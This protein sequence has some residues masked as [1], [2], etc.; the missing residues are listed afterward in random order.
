[1]KL[2]LIS[3]VRSPESEYSAKGVRTANVTRDTL[4]PPV[5]H[6]L[7]RSLNERIIDVSLRNDRARWRTA[8]RS[9]ERGT[10]GWW[11]RERERMVCR[12]SRNEIDFQIFFQTGSNPKHP[13]RRSADN[14]NMFWNVS[15]SLWGSLDWSEAGVS[16]L[17]RE[18]AVSSLSKRA[19][20]PLKWTAHMTQFLRAY[21][22]NRLKM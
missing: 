2:C 21:A 22:I 4:S 3:W 10:R 1:M 5:G 6:F 16:M 17:T 19:A 18:M 7:D 9:S 14:N 12:F 13:E 11:R 8:M 20:D 15:I